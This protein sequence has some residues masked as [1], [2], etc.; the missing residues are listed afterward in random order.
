MKR[1]FNKTTLLIAGIFFL[2]FTILQNFFFTKKSTIKGNVK[3]SF[4]P[5][6]L[7]LNDIEA[8]SNYV[9]ETAQKI[10]IRPEKNK[11][12]FIVLVD[13]IIRQRF[14]HGYSNFDMS[15]NYM[16]YIMSKIFWD[17][18]SAIVIPEDILKYPNAACSQQTILFME[19]LKKKE[20]L[21]RAARLKGHC[22]V[23]VF[24]KNS[25]HF[26]DSNIEPKT[27]NIF[28]M[29]SINE[30]RQDKELR[31]LIYKYKLDSAKIEDIFS[32]YHPSKNNEFI[33][34]KMYLFQIVTKFLS[35]W[36]WA[37][38]LGAYLFIRTYK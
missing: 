31:Q 13:D 2:C 35:D 37:I 26:F 18:L 16:A 3:E 11:R 8:L 5:Q 17:D 33:A 15:T 25:W 32:D 4:D 22:A 19:I 34:S 20:I 21:C 1:F 36:L 6:L 27:H 28:P 7:Y 14:Y 23:E 10:N 9:D 30:I 38:L 24:Y 29:P 12:E